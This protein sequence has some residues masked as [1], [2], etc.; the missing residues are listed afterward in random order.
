M[1]LKILSLIGLLAITS[2]AGNY[3]STSQFAVID[4]LDTAII[5]GPA[6]ATTN[7]ARANRFMM[8]VQSAI[9]RNIVET[10]DEG[11][12]AATKEQ[13][14]AVAGFDEQ[15]A[16]ARKRMPSV[17][18]RIDALGA[19]FQAAM[20]GPCAETLRIANDSTIQDGNTKA[21]VEMEKAC[22]PAFAAVLAKASAFTEEMQKMRETQSDEITATATRSARMTLI[23]MII[24]I[25]VISGIAVMVV[26]SGIVA[27]I[28][29]MMQVMSALGEGKLDDAVQG[30]DR[31]DEIGAMA[32]ALETLR[33]QL[34]AAEAARVAQAAAE[35]A[36]KEQIVRRGKLADAF[37]AQMQTLS[38]GFSQSS[39]EVADAAKSLSAT[40]EETS[41]QSQA[42]AAAA[43]EAATNVQ[44][45]A[46]SSEEMAA[47]VREISSQVGHSAQ[48]ADT[49]FNEAEASN[50]RIATLA[51][52][53]ASIGDVVN[54]INGIASQTNL[55]A[56]NATIE[57]ARAGEAG[58]GFAVVA[59][60]VKQLAA[61]TA[62]AT[63]VIAGQVS[64]I[65]AATDSSVKSMTEIVRVIGNIK[66]IAASISSAVE[67]QGAA[68]SEIA[69]N[70]QQAATGAT[71]VTQ[72][73]VGVGQAAEM[74]GTA[75]TQLMT[76]SGG[77]SSQAVDLKRVVESFV[78]DLNAA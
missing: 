6:S 76:L 18:D 62:K 22:K 53:A 55:L 16:D 64:A 12:R 21:A 70:C 72:N 74:T 68:T 8:A 65:Q 3:Y 57:A 42:V 71:Q 23:G 45:V 61:Q 54:L 52:A 69:R 5:N 20:T 1:I 66:E 35:A 33:G 48:V 78:H 28:R 10:S 58:K 7:I 9:Y 19:D 34:Q 67:E 27:P 26:R 31:A 50:V 47:S 13:T 56:L 59:S 39:T 24:A 63:E 4:D 29:Y 32:K 49:A 25:A 43:E 36:S 44:T 37:V 2:L 38:A 46:A 15:L 40:A 60:E 73:I 77:L 14:D 75:S 30:T 17:A 11:N 51:S 41:R